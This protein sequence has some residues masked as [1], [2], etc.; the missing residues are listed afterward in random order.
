MVPAA[1]AAG[2]PTAKKATA[3]EQTAAERTAND[4]RANTIPPATLP[5]QL[6]GDPV[7]MN[8]EAKCERARQ[9]RNDT[10]ES[11]PGSGPPGQG[12]LFHCL[13]C[14]EGRVARHP[15]SEADSR[16]QTDRSDSD[17]AGG[18]RERRGHQR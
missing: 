9:E 1:C 2:T 10:Y 16:K 3:A 17:D 11:R 14:R 13:G 4:F 12:P 6:F 5:P 8:T 18:Q 15:D 7:T